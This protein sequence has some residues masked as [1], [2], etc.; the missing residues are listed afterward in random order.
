MTPPCCQTQGGP[1]YPP[2]C[3]H[4]LFHPAQVGTF[5]VFGLLPQGRG[6]H[7][8]RIHEEVSQGTAFPRAAG[9]GVQVTPGDCSSDS[10]GL[11]KAH[12]C[13]AWPPLTINSFF[14]LGDTA[15]NLV[16]SASSSPCPHPLPPPLCPTAL[17]IDRCPHPASTSAPSL[18]VQPHQ[19]RGDG[20]S[21]RACREGLEKTRPALPFLAVLT[22]SPLLLG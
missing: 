15:R 19:A 22:N 3:G 10:L 16:H 2:C 21:P 4:Q 7:P 17:D 6:A 11:A 14:W 12:C 18:Q 1:L 5:G 20:A 13:P 9:A 8:P